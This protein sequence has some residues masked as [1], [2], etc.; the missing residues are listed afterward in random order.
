LADETISLGRL[1]RSTSRS[2]GGKPVF[3]GTRLTVD[4][5]VNALKAGANEEELLEDFPSL[6]REHIRAA[7][8]FDQVR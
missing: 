2:N 7:I 6:Q 4:L 3:K 5:I 8:L 1:H